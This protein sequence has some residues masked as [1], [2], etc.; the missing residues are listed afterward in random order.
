MMGRRSDDTTVAVIIPHRGRRPEIVTTLESIDRQS[1]D[2]TIRAIVVHDEGEPPE[3]APDDYSFPITRL[4]HVP[5]L[6][7]ND[8]AR[9]RNLGLAASHEDLIAFLD[10][11]DVWHDEK[12]A[13]QVDL[14]DALPSAVACSTG[15]IKVEGELRWPAVDTSTPVRELQLTEILWA[16]LI[17][18]SSV[19]MRGD[20]ARAL[21]FDERADW[22]AAEDFDLWVRSIDAGGFAHI[23]NQLTALRIDPAS[24]SRRDRLALHLASLAILQAALRRGRHRPAV[25]AAI[26]DRVLHL[27]MS[28][29]IGDLTRARVALSDTELGP[30]AWVAA[31]ERLVIRLG[32]RVR[33][34]FG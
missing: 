15:A 1:Y 10:D 2:G 5:V 27:A 20:V 26:A 14:L 30:P 17:V 11:D 8:I 18:C 6:G 34:P 13:R 12:L 25:A 22:F 3:Y 31:V 33:H 21:G 24:A 28:P 9:R 32:W 4:A 7:S 19:V 29:H 16:Q 23:P